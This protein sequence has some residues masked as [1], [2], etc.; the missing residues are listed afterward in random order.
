MR[1]WIFS[2][3]ENLISPLNAMQV[4][5][6]DKSIFL[7]V[8]APIEFFRGSILGAINLPL[9]GDEER[10]LVGTCYKNQ[11]KEKAI[12]L[13][14]KLLLDQ[15]SSREEDWLRWANQEINPI[16]FCARGGLRSQ[17]TQN[18]LK[19]RGKSVSRI[20][21]GYKAMRSL[22]REIISQNRPY[23]V[24]GGHTGSGKTRFIAQSKISWSGKMIDLESLA[25][26]R[27]SAF[28]KPILKPQPSP[29]DFENAL[30]MNL[31]KIAANQL[32]LVEDESKMIGK[33]RLPDTFYQHIAAADLLFLK[34]PL[35]ER[36]ENIL[37]DYVKDIEAKHGLEVL[38]TTLIGSLNS[39]KKKLGMERFT[40][41][42]GLVTS[43]IDKADDNY[44]RSW[45]ETLLEDYYDPMYDYS[46][47]KKNRNI[48]FQGNAI[49]LS[50]YL[51]AEMKP[52]NQ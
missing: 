30:A 19:L 7:D 44:H 34:V 36:V 25:N 15:R 9:L 45:I 1:D 27:G 41:L 11:G 26:H 35:K 13:G 16:L 51:I 24:L 12:D 37:Q 33:I 8:R 52:H 5:A 43:A 47:K 29:Q 40:Q 32:T 48:R 14:E 46:M 50:Q 31:F 6:E 49:E 10:A 42:I 20:E 17:V 4:L 39:I 23:I 22:N 21:G 28:G 3:K 2:A 38:K 18:W